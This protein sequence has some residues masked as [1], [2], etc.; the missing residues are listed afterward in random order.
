M[1]IGVKCQFFIHQ[2]GNCKYRKKLHQMRQVFRKKLHQIS[3]K[4]TPN[5]GKNYTKYR[6]NL[7][8]MLRFF[9]KTYTKC[10]KNLHQMPEKIM[11]NNLASGS[12]T[13]IPHSENNI[14]NY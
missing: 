6:K 5:T 9:G 3:E 14:E 1:I 12:C 4:I 8:Q 2:T 13:A 7:H 10:R 11:P